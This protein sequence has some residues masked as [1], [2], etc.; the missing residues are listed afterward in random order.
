MVSPIQ[1][2]KASSCLR[3]SLI[4]WC[5]KKPSRSLRM[6]NLTRHLRTTSNFKKHRLQLVRTEWKETWSIRLSCWRIWTS[7]RIRFSV[8]S[9]GTSQTR[10]KQVLMI[11]QSSITS[12]RRE[13]S[14]QWALNPI[15][16]TTG[17]APIKV[18]WVEHTQKTCHQPLKILNN[19][20]QWD[21]K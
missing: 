9:S 10:R 4:H 2:I 8:S 1:P 20:H 21:S 14:T 17:Q 18:N 13:I 15:L 6:S 5:S 7:S 12:S 19:S 16:V 11:M 3:G